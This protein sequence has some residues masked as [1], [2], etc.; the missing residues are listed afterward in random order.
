MNTTTHT[1]IL[2]PYRLPTNVRPYHYDLVVKTDLEQLTFEGFVKMRYFQL[3][4]PLWSIKSFTGTLS[5]LD[6]ENETSEIVLN[7]SHLELLEATVASNTWKSEK[8]AIISSIDDA[9]ERV[10]YRVP[11]TLISGSKAELKIRFAGT[12]AG[13]M[14]GYYRARWDHKGTTEY[15][16]LTQLA[17][18]SARRAFPCWDEPQLKA[19]Y[20]LTLI[21]RVGTVNLSNMP[22]L[23]EEPILDGIPGCNAEWKTTKFE[24][25]PPMSTYIV[26]YA[27]GPFVFI[28]TNIT[29]PLSGKSVPLRIYTTRDLIHQAQFALDVKAAALPLYEE[30]FDIE[31]P[32]PKLD[33]LVASDFGPGAME[34][35]GLITGRLNAFLI[36]PDRADIR[37]KKEV[38]ATQSHEVAH[39]WFG[40]FTTMEWWSYF[41]LNE[42]RLFGERYLPDKC[43]L[44]KAVISSTYLWQHPR[45]YPEWRGGIEFINKHLN[46][47]LKKDANIS[48]QPIEVEFSSP[49]AINQASS[50]Y[51]KAAA[52][53]LM[54][55]SYV[56]EEK[57]FQGV[58]IYLK[59]KRFSNSVTS[60]LWDGISAATGINI[61]E[62]MDNWINKAGFP[63]VTVTEDASGI[64]VRQNRF[65][66]TEVSPAE[67][68]DTIWSIPLRILTVDKDGDP[69]INGN[70]IL[71]EREKTIAL[72][73]S[74]PFKLNAG[75]K[76]RVLYTD[77][78]L[79]LMAAEAIKENSVFSLEDRMGLIHDAVAVAKAGLSKLSSALTFVKQ[80]KKEKQYLVW[81]AIS[82][83]LS[84]VQDVW[85]ENLAITERFK[86]FC[87]AYEACDNRVVNEL[88]RRFKVYE[89]TGDDS[90]I[91]AD[92]QTVIYS[93]ATRYGGSEEYEMMVRI[94]NN[95]KTTTEKNAAM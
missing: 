14:V 41:Y 39:M 5:S 38:A 63:V 27:N 64:A 81:Q 73:K 37:A 68:D 36:D 45:V 93:A 32:L 59:R 40:N 16:A 60:D 86:E 44:F 35:W 20:A 33:T 71:Q 66:D 90:L 94:Y 67:N 47:A 72:D 78:R 6:I 46:E 31:Y 85:W 95:P 76:D 58:S 18:T 51:S 55:S 25:T 54:L 23:S 29:M 77:E 1:S 30:L 49:N 43:V 28:E 61:S 15:Y 62:L 48:T 17:T 70:S 92:L 42:G 9:K 82:E 89:Q 52:V 2:D 26:A 4:I 65:L 74:K 8:N 13:N 87:R 22:V 88:R 79:S 34:N 80:F 50:I 24:K 10:T 69:I 12:L 11:E 91:P 57:F 83:N 7:A 19:T 21:S 56:G 84:D 3:R 75:T 53:L